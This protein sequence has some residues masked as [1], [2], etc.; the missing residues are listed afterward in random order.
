M[1]Y[2]LTKRSCDLLRITE[3]FLKAEGLIVF[4]GAEEQIPLSATIDDMEAYT[5]VTGE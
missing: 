1:C 2:V 5:K 4:D 3:A